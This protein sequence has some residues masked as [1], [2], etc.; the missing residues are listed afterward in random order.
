MLQVAITTTTT[1]LNMGHG[2]EAG[3]GGGGGLGGNWYMPLLFTPPCKEEPPGQLTTPSMAP[4]IIIINATV[5]G[6]GHH[7]D[8]TPTMLTVCYSAY[9]TPP[10]SQQHSRPT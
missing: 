3:I 8:N 4:I 7:P 2:D 1:T 10:Y 6:K 9:I 5:R